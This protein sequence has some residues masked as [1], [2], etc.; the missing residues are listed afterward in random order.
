MDY[1]WNGHAWWVV[2]CRFRLWVWHWRRAILT[3]YF[4]TVF[5]VLQKNELW[6]RVYCT[7]ISFLKF[8]LCS[9]CMRRWIN[10][11]SIIMAQSSPKMRQ[12]ALFRASNLKIFRGGG[13][14]YPPM[15]GGIPR[16]I[17]SPPR[18]SGACKALKHLIKLP[19]RL[20]HFILLLLQNLGRT[21]YR[22]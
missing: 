20:L 22:S 7:C 1:F 19:W 16:P 12:N 18:A 3:H 8:L 13:P 21:L 6:C 15:G 9:V 4:Q 17:P 10:K 11:S 14:P 5:A 2:W